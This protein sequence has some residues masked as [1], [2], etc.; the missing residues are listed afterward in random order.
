MIEPKDFCGKEL[1]TALIE[2]NINGCCGHFIYDKD[3]SKLKANRQILTVRT[4]AALGY[5]L[6]I[7]LYEAQKFFRQKHN[8]HIEIIYHDTLWYEYL[9]K[10]SGKIIVQ[11]SGYTTYENALVTAIEKTV[12]SIKSLMT[13]QEFH[14]KWGDT[15]PWDI[16]NENVLREYKE[17]CFKMWENAGFKERYM[18]KIDPDEP[19]N[20][21]PFKVLRRATEEE[22]E[23]HCMPLWLVEL[24]DGHTAYCGP[25]EI[26]KF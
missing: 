24:Y 3:A 25:D 5:T 8:I 10:K 12:E 17:D 15:D 1:S 14:D 20:N 7:S 11:G 6:A 13:R 4:A 22:C 16:E 9:V 18:S 21:T 2:M 23:L 26:C 19:Y